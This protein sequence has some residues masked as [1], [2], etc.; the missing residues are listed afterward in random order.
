MHD[1][2]DL[3]MNFVKQKQKPNLPVAFTNLEEG[4]TASFKTVLF[5]CARRNLSQHQMLGL[6]RDQTQTQPAVRFSRVLLP[7]ASTTARTGIPISANFQ[8]DIYYRGKKTNNNKKPKQNL[9]F[10]FTKYILT[11]CT[12]AHEKNL[13]NLT[14]LI[15]YKK[16]ENSLNHLALVCGQSVCSA[17]GQERSLF[18]KQTL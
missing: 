17:P 2:P 3:H 18:M 12:H 13:L 9:Y 7:F 16:E 10:H 8:T 4:I 6:L 14:T 15:R 5:Q 11:T 1:F